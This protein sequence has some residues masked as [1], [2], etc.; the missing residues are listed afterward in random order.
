MS[1]LIINLIMKISAKAGLVIIYVV[2][3]FLGATALQANPA[4]MKKI[5]EFT[6]FIQDFGFLG[7]LI[8]TTS[9]AVLM[10]LAIPLQFVDMIVGII[11]PVKEATL[12]LIG[13][14]LLGAA[15]T[16]YVANHI[17]SE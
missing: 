9:S 5:E 12:I 15:M 14:K 10:V 13:S 4:F 8:Y 6:K 2:V 16:Y 17:I 11:Y 1:W 3:V 7:M